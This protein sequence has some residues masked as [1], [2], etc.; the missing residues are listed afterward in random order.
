LNFVVVLLVFLLSAIVVTG[1]IWNEHQHRL[2]HE[3]TEA[4]LHVADHA[5][6]LELVHR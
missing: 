4:S 5:L 2:H 1:A 6:A 3:R